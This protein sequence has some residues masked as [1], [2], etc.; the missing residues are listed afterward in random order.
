M[1]SNIS[2]KHEL[3][4]SI[5][6]VNLFFVFFYEKSPLRINNKIK[7]KDEYA[8]ELS[9]LPSKNPLFVICICR[10]KGFLPL[11]VPYMPALT[12]VEF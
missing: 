5:E 7:N 11:V 8:I 10:Q 9:R 12:R 2:I 3:F 4:E 6:F 1:R